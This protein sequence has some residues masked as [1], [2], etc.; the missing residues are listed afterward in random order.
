MTN[1]QKKYGEKCNK[2]HSVQRRDQ[3][4]AEA[5]E[6]QIRK[7]HDGSEGSGLANGGYSKINAKQAGE[8]KSAKEAHGVTLENQEYRSSKVSM[9]QGTA[10]ERDQ[11]MGESHSER[12]LINL[13]VKLNRK[14]LL[15]TSCNVAGTVRKNGGAGI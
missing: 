13:A 7:P 5:M 4:V 1:Q 11:E 14:Q 2:V 9:E 12:D 8:G 15:C 6:R 3:Q 10:H